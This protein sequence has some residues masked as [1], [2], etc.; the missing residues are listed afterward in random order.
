LR[1]TPAVAAIGLPVYHQSSHAATLGR[2]HTPLDN[3][4]PIVCAGVTVFPGDILVGD[5]EGVCVIPA[6]LA[7]EIA[8][9]SYAQ[10]LE[11]EWALGRVAAGDSSSDTFP[12]APG[13]RAEFEQWL[14][15]RPS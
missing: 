8:N 6:L 11:E 4:I 2:L 9:D 13:R 1:D 14:A 7:E 15:A 12:I 3:Q 5:G 10:E